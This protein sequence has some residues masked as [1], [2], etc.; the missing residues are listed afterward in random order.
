MTDDD[1]EKLV[2]TNNGDKAQHSLLTAAQ[3]IFTSN[4][5]GLLLLLLPDLTNKQSET[6]L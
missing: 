2:F 6:G 1:V 5:T 4:F 3:V